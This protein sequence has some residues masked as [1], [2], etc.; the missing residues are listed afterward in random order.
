MGLLYMGASQPGASCTNS[1]LSAFVDRD[2]EFV[3][4]EVLPSVERFLN[5]KSG[6][7]QQ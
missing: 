5:R 6:R 4:G 3:L 2:A 7:N 1:V